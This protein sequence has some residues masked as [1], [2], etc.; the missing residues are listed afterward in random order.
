MTVVS[1]QPP[2]GGL[3]DMDS[4]A[5]RMNVPTTARAAI[6]LLFSTRLTP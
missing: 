3:A 5:S 6:G 4:G 2:T 1:A